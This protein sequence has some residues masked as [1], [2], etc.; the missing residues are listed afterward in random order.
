MVICYFFVSINFDY[1]YYC[2]FVNFYGVIYLYFG[3]FLMYRWI[4]FYL[5]VD[6]CLGGFCGIFNICIFF[7]WL[8]KSKIGFFGNR[9][10]VF[11]VCVWLFLVENGVFL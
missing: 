3:I 9:L 2:L 1:C 4:E 8:I 10:M 5:F 11:Q 6:F 7:F